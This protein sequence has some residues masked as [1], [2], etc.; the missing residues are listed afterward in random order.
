MTETSK[1]R[2]LVFLLFLSSLRFLI[3]TTKDDKNQ[4]VKEIMPVLEDVYYELE[5]KIDDFLEENDVDLE[6]KKI[7]RENLFKFKKNSKD[8]E[9]KLIS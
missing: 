6:T 4:E 9:K 5:G 7:L 8:I 3:A 1:M 2:V